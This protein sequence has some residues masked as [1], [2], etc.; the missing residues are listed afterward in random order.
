[1]INEINQVGVTGGD[2]CWPKGLP[3]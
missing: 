2:W 1:L 3:P